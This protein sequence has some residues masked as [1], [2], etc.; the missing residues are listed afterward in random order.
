M[1][2]QPE[3]RMSEGTGVFL[4]VLAIVVV[5]G[6]FTNW[7]GFADSE[8]SVPTTPTQDGADQQAPLQLIPAIE[9]TK[10]YVSTYDQAD[11]DDEGKKNRV[12]GTA[13][14][15]KSGVSIDEV[16]TL[17]TGAA[18]ST[19]EFNGGDRVSALASAPGYYASAT[20]QIEI[21]ETLKP[22]EVFMQAA[23]TPTVGIENDQ[24]DAASTMTLAAN[25][26][27]KRHAI[28]IE[29]PGDDTQYNFCGIAAN[30]DDEIVDPRLKVAGSYEEGLMN[31]DEDYDALDAAG[32][33]AVW[34]YDQPIADFDEVEIDFLIGTEKDVDPAGTNVTFSVFDCEQNI[35]SGEIVY[36][37]EDTADADVGL[38]NIAATITVN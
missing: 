29:R 25:E 16:T 31:L 7:Y 22:I 26:V 15:I 36:T 6:S 10:V 5:V 35:Q 14:L 37:N 20:E 19:A 38:A 24:G 28:V 9:K 30:F 18:A 13:E 34:A 12:A 27:S 21:D 23:G 3:I 2:K 33:D 32:F 11:F 1:A 4:V 8:T 17:T